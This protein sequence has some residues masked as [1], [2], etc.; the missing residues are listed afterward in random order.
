MQLLADNFIILDG[1]VNTGVLRVGQRAILFDCCDSVTPERL[2]QLGIEQVEMVCCTQPRRQHMAGS[3]AFAASGAGLAVAA[4]G[5][6]CYEQPQA[7]WENWVKRWVGAE[8]RDGHPSRA[9]QPQPEVPVSALPVT[10]ALADGDVITWEGYAIHALALQPIRGSLAFVVEVAG[11]RYCFAGDY[12]YAPGQFWELHPFQEDYLDCHGF[13]PRES[14]LLGSLRKI[15]ATQADVVIPAHGEPF[16]DVQNAVQTTIRAVEEVAETYRVILS[17]SADYLTEAPPRV[18]RIPRGTAHAI[19]ADD[20]AA[21][22]ADLGDDCAVW[23]I[24]ELRRQ[25]VLTSVD[26]V[27]VTHF[28]GDHHWAMNH[29]FY[30]YPECRVIADEHQADILQHPARYASRCLTSRPIPVHQ[31]VRDGESWAWKEYTLTNFHFPAHTYYHGALLVE[32]HGQRWLFTGDSV[33]DGLMLGEYC[34]QNRLMVGADAGGARCLRIVEETRPDLIFCGHN[35]RPTTW[36]PELLKCKQAAYQRREALL[37]AMIPWTHPNFALDPEWATTY[38]Y[39]QDAAAGSSCRLDVV[40]LNHASH[41][42]TA[43]IDWV[44]P[45]G[46]HA[47]G[48][49]D[50]PRAI[51]GN[52]TGALT[53]RLHIPPATPAG[54]YVLPVRITWDGRY[55]G[56]FRHALLHVW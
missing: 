55:L 16:A 31:P 7:Y 21:L 37:T 28:H 53:R 22:L 40:F 33:A 19:I 14:P 32:G 41:P 25:G 51:A 52:T 34:A 15:A 30:Y 12:L 44:L 35:A 36:T 23:D 43:L 20:G 50:A 3:Y 56:Q 11:K 2:A 47:E 5:R 29:L 18:V 38:P 17:G 9:L 26:A 6:E 48:G 13:L 46:W 10:Q 54:L 45:A 4:E 49:E 24:E 8:S 27:Y 1:A 42:A 39:E